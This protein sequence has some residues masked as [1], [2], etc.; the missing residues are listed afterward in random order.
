MLKNALAAVGLA[1]L[2][3]AGYCAYCQYKEMERENAFWRKTAE[4]QGN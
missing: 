4:E 2:V 1:V 3:K